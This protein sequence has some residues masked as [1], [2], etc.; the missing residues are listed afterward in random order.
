MR[1][2]PEVAVNRRAEFYGQYFLE[3]ASSG[4]QPTV[5]P[6]VIGNRQDEE[7]SGGK[8]TEDL[9]HPLADKSSGT[10]RLI[11]PGGEV[12][13]HKKKGWHR[14]YLGPQ[15]KPVE[16]EARRRIVHRPQQSRY[17]CSH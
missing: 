16:R 15:T 5:R 13:C 10:A 14:R 2:S 9:D 12:A 8:R 17:R 7:A 3:R 1:R 11:E 4:D 6:Y